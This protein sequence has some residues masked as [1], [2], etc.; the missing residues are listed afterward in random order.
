MKRISKEEWMRRDRKRL[1]KRMEASK[2]NTGKA[3][4]TA[5]SLHSHKT[6]YCSYCL[7]WINTSM[8]MSHWIIMDGTDNCST[9]TNDCLRKHTD[10]KMKGK[11]RFVRG[12]VTHFARLCSRFIWFRWWSYARLWRKMNYSSWCIRINPHSQFA[13]MWKSRATSW[14]L[15]DLKSNKNV[16]KGKT[17]NWRAIRKLYIRND[18]GLLRSFWEF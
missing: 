1:E 4:I 14:C 8:P 5:F 16:E 11:P 12:S 2:I 18:Y 9:L 15:P 17:D 3:N 6:E 10:K 7:C 13:N